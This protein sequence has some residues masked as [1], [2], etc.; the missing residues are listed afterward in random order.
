MDLRQA[1]RGSQALFAAWSSTDFATCDLISFYPIM[2]FAP[3]ENALA[4]P[5]VSS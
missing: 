1:F 3:Y 2:T 5:A 4:V